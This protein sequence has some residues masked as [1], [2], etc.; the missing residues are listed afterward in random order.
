M[1]SG[2]VIT[3]A[4]LLC[5]LVITELV[6]IFLV[7]A[8]YYKDD[9]RGFNI[10]VYEKND[11]MFEEKLR[12]YIRQ[13]KWRDTAFADKIYIVHMNVPKAQSAGICEMCRERR[14]LVYLSIDEFIKIICND[15]NS[16]ERDCILSENEV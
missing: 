10:I 15:K 14:D 5:I 16:L 12:D 7:P 2:Y 11:E 1:V 8:G 9:I 6:H 3:A 4:V 13:L